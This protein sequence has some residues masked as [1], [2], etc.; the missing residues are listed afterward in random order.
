[1]TSKELPTKVTTES[2]IKVGDLVM[3]RDV[4]WPIYRVEKIKWG[5][6]RVVM[7]RS[8]NHFTKVDRKTLYGKE[9]D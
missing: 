6:A 4:T 9:D 7:V 3:W 1:M 8:L 5:Q 2:S